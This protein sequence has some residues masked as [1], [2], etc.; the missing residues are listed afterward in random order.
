M[1]LEPV[2]WFGAP[3]RRCRLGARGRARWRRVYEGK[4]RG[5]EGDIVRTC[6]CE[7]PAARAL[8]KGWIGAREGEV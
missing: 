3:C 1:Y 6:S 7:L 4:G 5:G 2:S 8:Q